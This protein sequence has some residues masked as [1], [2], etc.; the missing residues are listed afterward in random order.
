MAALEAQTAQL[1]AELSAAYR[2]KAGRT[3]EALAATRQLG[4]VRDICEA[5][6]RE[7]EGERAE[8]ARLR[9]QVGGRGARGFANWVLHSNSRWVVGAA[10]TRRASAAA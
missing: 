3:E 9:E 8:G 4:V 1:Q 7:L 6:T 5:T 10:P 2:D